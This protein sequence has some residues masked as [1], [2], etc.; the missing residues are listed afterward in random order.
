MRFRYKYWK[1]V[2][3]DPLILSWIKGY[4]IPFFRKPIQGIPPTEPRWDYT[5]KLAIRKHIEKL[6]LTGAVI[7]CSPTKNQFISRIFLAPKPDG[8]CRLILNLKRLNKFVN[9]KHFKLEDHRTVTKLLTP[10]CFL[11]SI[12]LKDAYH[13]VSVNKSYRKYLR[14]KFDN[15][16]YE[17][18]CL[19]FGLNSCPFVF[20]KV[21]KPVLAFLRNKNFLSNLYLDDFLLIGKTFQDCVVNVFETTTILEK[22]GFIINKK[23]S[24]LTPKQK[25]KYLGFEYNTVEMTLQ[26]PKN[27]QVKIQVLL[28]KFKIGHKYKI[29]QFSKLVGKLV[30]VCPAIRYSWVYTKRMERAKFLALRAS[31]GDYDSFMQLPSSLKNDFSWWK[32]HLSSFNFIKPQKFVLEIFSDASLSG[33]GIVSNNKKSHGFWS[34]KDKKK[35]INYLE[36]LAASFGLKCFAKNLFNCNILLRIDNTTAIAYIN[37]MGGVQYPHLNKL[38]RSIWQWCEQRNIWIVASYINT[39]LNTQ[40]DTES[41]RLTPQT[42]YELSNIVFQ[43]ICTHLSVPKI[44]IF[45]SRTN[46]KCKFFISWFPDP[47]AIAV[48]AF[49]VSWSSLD[50]YAFPPFNLMGKVLQKVISDKARGIVIAPNWPTQSWF[51]LFMSLCETKPIIIEPS[52][53][54]LFSVDRKPH[55]LNKSLSL[56]AGL[57]SCKL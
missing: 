28:S 44:D 5:Q 54:L 31:K 23:K 2:T 47:E 17:Y 7:E 51:P 56:V 20:T 35:H 53:D 46:T 33:W 1:Q 52:S 16:L 34:F 55:P 4:K 39:S 50:F 13:L 30:S 32:F 24:Q 9:T 21:M 25:L 43:D 15:K 11:A 37:R 19:P 10:S 22:L 49:T 3:S 6:L 26:V 57:L 14:F 12:D 18:T 27:K 41:R 48:D 42:E 36:L 29:R 40:A 8:S 38:A 45:A